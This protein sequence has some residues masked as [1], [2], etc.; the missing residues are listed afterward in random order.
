MTFHA[1]CLLNTTFM[2][3]SPERYFS[4]WKWKKGILISELQRW[5]SMNAFLGTSAIQLDWNKWS[6]ESLWT[7]LRRPDISGQVFCLGGNNSYFSVALRT[8]KL[9]WKE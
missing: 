1:Q 5:K 4:G 7:K 6:S 2:M 9:D 3:E 8:V